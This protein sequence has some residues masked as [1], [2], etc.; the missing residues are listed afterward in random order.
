MRQSYSERSKINHEIM[1][2][3]GELAAENYHGQPAIDE[4]KDNVLNLWNALFTVRY[5]CSCYRILENVM[6]LEDSTPLVLASLQGKK[7][8]ESLSYC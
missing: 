6:S 1:L 4:R 5:F 3:S 2:I 8:Q 7:T